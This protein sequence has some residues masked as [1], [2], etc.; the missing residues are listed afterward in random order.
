MNDWMTGWLDYYR[1]IPMQKLKLNIPIINSSDSDQWSAMT[2]SFTLR[3]DQICDSFVCRLQWCIDLRNGTTVPFRHSLVF[4][5]RTGGALGQ[6][7]PP[8]LSVCDGWADVVRHFSLDHQL[9]EY[10]HNIDV[11]FRWTLNV[12][13]LPVEANDTLSHFLDINITYWLDLS[14]HSSTLFS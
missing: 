11:I 10:L 1:H 3:F 9:L 4:A 6:R 12:S 7:A 2:M 5:D 14:A 8:R 13:V